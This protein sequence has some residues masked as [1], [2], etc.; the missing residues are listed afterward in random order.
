MTTVNKVIRWMKKENINM[1]GMTL[2]EDGCLDNVCH[3]EQGGKKYTIEWKGNG[4][5]SVIC[6]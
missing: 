1:K 2:W 4:K 3:V 5:Y 6:W